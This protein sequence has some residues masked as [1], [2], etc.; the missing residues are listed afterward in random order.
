LADII[1]VGIIEE[2]KLIR[3]VSH[4][5]RT[6]PEAQSERITFIQREFKRISVESRRE[7]TWLGWSQTTG[8]PPAVRP[9]SG[10]ISVGVAPLADGQSRRGVF[11]L[12]DGKA[13]FLATSEIHG[14][15]RAGKQVRGLLSVDDL[16][17]LIGLQ[18]DDLD[19]LPHRLNNVG[20]GCRRAY[21]CWRR[22]RDVR[23]KPEVTSRSSEW[24][25]TGA[26][27]EDIP[28]GTHHPGSG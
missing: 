18:L 19:R 8:V 10:R 27:R 12:V 1:R 26:R 2:E 21:R 14:Y 22:P 13:L 28:N 24:W 15:R 9:L 17:D 23:K 25:K 4:T 11:A 6:S 16:R 5:P 20:G 3:A 7:K